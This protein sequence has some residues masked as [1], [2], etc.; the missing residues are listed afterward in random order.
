MIT[1][2][3]SE[4]TSTTPK[5]KA[6]TRET[7]GS[8]LQMREFTDKE[9]YTGCYKWYTGSLGIMKKVPTG[10]IRRIRIK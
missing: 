2:T 1:F 7:V 5:S 6:A 10:K 9:L 8:A 3:S 4:R